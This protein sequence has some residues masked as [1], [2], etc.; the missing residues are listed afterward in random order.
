MRFSFCLLFLYIRGIYVII[1]VGIS[2]SY[3]L[4]S[5]QFPAEWECTFLFQCAKLGIA[6][7]KYFCRFLRSK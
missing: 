1:D 2:I 3:C 4:I 6:Y 7:G 5:N